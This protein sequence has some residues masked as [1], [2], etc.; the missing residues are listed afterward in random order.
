MIIDAPAWLKA[1][2]LLGVPALLSIWLTHF[3]TTT[4]SKSIDSLV[5][6]NKA[7]TLAVGTSSSEHKDMREIMTRLL[8]TTQTICV[9]G[10]RTDDARARCV[11]LEPR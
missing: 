10:A 7:L 6:S 9:N 2:V 4:Q 8:A 5:E 1:A 3:I 11:G